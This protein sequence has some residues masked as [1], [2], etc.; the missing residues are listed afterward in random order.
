MNSNAKQGEKVSGANR[1]SDFVSTIS[2]R[3]K[4]KYKL[5]NG[6]SLWI[7]FVV[8]VSIDGPGVTHNVDASAPAQG[9]DPD[10]LWK[11]VNNKCVP[12]QLHN[13]DPY[14]CLLVDLNKG[15]AL[16]KDREG[17]AQVLLIPT[18]RITGIESS[19]VL[20]HESPNYFG[21]AWHARAIVEALIHKSLPRYAISLA[22]N[23]QA[24]RSQDQLHIHIDCLRSDVSAVLR[25]AKIEGNWGP[26]GMPISGHE[27]MAIRMAGDE[28]SAN[29]FYVLAN[30]LPEARK[31]MGQRTLIVVGA[32]LDDGQPGFIIL[33]SRADLK[34]GNSGHGEELQD[35]SCS[36]EGANVSQSR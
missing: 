15:Y 34:T 33:E 31:D 10:I 22:V 35:H 26:L 30:Q 13:Q 4:R 5:F 2:Y 12:N 36:L 25:R 18:S 14:P 28:L 27:Y 19:E 3:K 9:S 20:D 23:S 11:I 7:A 29:P 24:G 32:I 6:F 16:L 21:D 8:L 1:K 17:P